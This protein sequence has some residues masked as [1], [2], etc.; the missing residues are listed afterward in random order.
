MKSDPICIVFERIFAFK[1]QKLQLNSLYIDIRLPG[2]IEHESLRL[3]ERGSKFESEFRIDA[4]KLL[5]DDMI[6]FYVKCGFYYFSNHHIE[7]LKKMQN[8]K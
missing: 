4:E 1:N 7:A 3:K 8:L 6:D 2:K 5:D